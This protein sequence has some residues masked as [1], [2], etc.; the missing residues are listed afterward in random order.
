[1]NES[2]KHLTRLWLKLY[3]YGLKVGIG[4]VIAYAVFGWV[5]P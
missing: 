1:M 2:E 3:E 4:L 5:R